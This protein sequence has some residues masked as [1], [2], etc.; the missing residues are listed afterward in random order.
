MK[1]YLLLITTFLSANISAQ[2]TH[3][4]IFPFKSAIIEY[5][6]E[7]GQGGTHVKYID[8]YGYK[9]A[10]YIRKEFK[11]GDN[12][13]K[14]HQTIILEGSRA[15]TIDYKDSTVAIG[16]NST[17]TYY[18]QNSNRKPSEVTEALIRAEGFEENGTKEF[19]GK[20]CKYWK[21]QK[22]KKLTWNGVDIKTTT[23]FMMMMV[24]KATS[25]KIDVDLPKNAFDIPQGLRYIS[26][27]VYQGYSGLEL[28]FDED[29][30][31]KPEDDGSIKIEFSSSSLEDTS[32][33]PFYS[34]EGEEI[35]QSGANDYNKVDFKIIKSQLSAMK[36][37]IVELEKYQTLVFKQ[38]N[39]YGE[40]FNAFG[41]IQINKIEDGNFSYRYITFDD[42]EEI[43]GYS[44]DDNLAFTNAFDIQINKNN[45]KLIITPKNNTECIVLGL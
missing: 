34:Q 24:E 1:Y 26:S 42:D 8:D 23:T 6:Y 12:I 37:E 45:S 21:A 35:I 33:I 18:L 40:G 20:E 7:A 29:N 36:P 10:D 11:Y 5:K 31:P 38:T 28:K 19:L 25:I 32:K 30:K 14:E 39:G 16:F 15:Y 3:V 13:E 27:D 41:K 43:T 22:A 17:Y 9:Q 4:K 2:E 44:D